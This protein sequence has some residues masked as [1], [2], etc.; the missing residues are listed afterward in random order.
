VNQLPTGSER[1]QL[2]PTRGR[3]APKQPHVMHRSRGRFGPKPLEINA[4][5]GR[6]AEMHRDLFLESTHLQS[7]QGLARILADW[8]GYDRP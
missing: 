4:R 2:R 6:K 7:P 1:V 5:G 8:T 3:F